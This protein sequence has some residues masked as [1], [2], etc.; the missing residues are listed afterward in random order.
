MARRH[1]L[2]SLLNASYCFSTVDKL[3]H[4]LV[5]TA[6]VKMEQW[7]LYFSVW[8]V[9]HARPNSI[10]PCGNNYINTCLTYE[11]CFKYGHIPLLVQP[12]SYVFEDAICFLYSKHCKTSVDCQYKL[13]KVHK[14]EVYNA[15][16]IPSRQAL[17]KVAGRFQTRVLRVNIAVW[18]QREVYTHSHQ[19]PLEA[20][21]KRQFQAPSVHTWR[22]R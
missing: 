6:L 18:W 9:N 20:A 4:I 11:T 15:K 22:R 17:L 2:A 13:Y 1:V 7:W 8:F 5:K 16:S 19:V 3:M 12:L 14:N 10:L 21:R